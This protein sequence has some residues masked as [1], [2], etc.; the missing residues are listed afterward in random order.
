MRGGG[1][2]MNVGFSTWIGSATEESRT[3]CNIMDLSLA[4]KSKQLSINGV[5]PITKNQ[6]QMRMEEFSLFS[7]NVT[8]SIILWTILFA[9][10]LHVRP[11]SPIFSNQKKKIRR[12]RIIIRNYHT[13]TRI[14]IFRERSLWGSHSHVQMCIQR[15]FPP[16]IRKKKEE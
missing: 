1:D 15:Y 3:C 6:L 5:F 8:I 7:P 12:K 11:T 2:A 16:T 13:R 4:H 9:N 10:M 14:V